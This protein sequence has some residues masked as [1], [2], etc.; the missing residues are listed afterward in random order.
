ML[1]PGVDLLELRNKRGDTAWTHLE[2]LAPGRDAEF[3][4]FGKGCHVR[5]EIPEI[6]AG[7]AP[8]PRVDCRYAEKCSGSVMVGPVRNMCRREQGW[9][10]LDSGGHLGCGQFANLGQVDEGY[11][12][13]GTVGRCPRH[14]L[15]DLVL[16]GREID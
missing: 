4:E 2:I 14:P 7:Q 15:G 9:V 6:N 5:D 13:V 3:T 1:C 8:G 16:L 11:L 12:H 10:P